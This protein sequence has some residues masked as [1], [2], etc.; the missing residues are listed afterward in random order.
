MAH[1]DI[2]TG[3]N[4]ISAL[5]QVDSNGLKHGLWRICTPNGQLWYELNY[6]DD[7]LNGIWRRWD[8]NDEHL[9]SE[10]NCVNG[11]LEGETIQYDY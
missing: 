6:A 11:F 10:G 5:N 1:I 3:N 2:G 9:R 4:I 8:K 7:W